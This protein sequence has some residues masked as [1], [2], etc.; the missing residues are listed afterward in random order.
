MYKNGIFVGE[1]ISYYLDGKKKMVCEIVDSVYFMCQFWFF[2]FENKQLIKDGNGEYFDFYI[3]GKY[4]EWY[5]YKNGLKDGYFEEYNLYGQ[6]LINGLFR[7]GLKDLI[8]NYVYY[9]GVIEKI[10][11]YK[12]GLF[13]GFYIY[14]Y[15]NG[16]VNVQG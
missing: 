13:D 1:W 3:F 8:W 5:Y 2:V 16:K 14:F 11:N 10:F 4:K 9:I 6:V 15:D 7:E 12:N